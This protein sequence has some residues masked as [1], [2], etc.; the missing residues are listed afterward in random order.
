MV[1]SA[2]KHA[3]RTRGVNGCK[4]NLRA[5]VVSVIIFARRV[6][7]P[8]SPYLKGDKTVKLDRRTG[9]VTHQ[10]GDT[11][12]VVRFSCVLTY[13]P[14]D[15][16]TP[17]MRGID[18][19]DITSVVVDEAMLPSEVFNDRLQEI[20]FSLVEAAI[21]NQEFDAVPDADDI[22]ADI[23]DEKYHARKDGEV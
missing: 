4:G 12:F 23:G 10:D 11:E 17:P 15:R 18:G 1:R 9:T 6:R 3:G 5:L 19:Y 22:A 2:P 21:E 14:G 16:D 13:D 7:F 8:P 20:F